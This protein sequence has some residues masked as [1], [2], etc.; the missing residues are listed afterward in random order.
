MS[1]GDADEGGIYSGTDDDRFADADESDLATSGVLDDA[2]EDD[3]DD[4]DGGG[5][6]FEAGRHGR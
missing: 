2:E 5:F 4:D 1:A 6:S 3:G